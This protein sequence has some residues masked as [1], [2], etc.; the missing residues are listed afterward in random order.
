MSNLLRKRRV[1]TSNS[2]TSGGGGGEMTPLQ[3]KVAYESNTN[4]NA[5]TDADEAIV[6]AQG[7]INTTLQ[8]NIDAAN[9]RSMINAL[10][11]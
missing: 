9:A 5:F 6:D 3:I 1:I 7:G 2:V 10:I 4:T 8:T 11:F